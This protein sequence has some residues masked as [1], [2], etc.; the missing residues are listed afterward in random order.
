M[1]L[2]S[3]F[4]WRYAP[5]A[6]FFFSCACIMIVELVAGRLIAGHLGS[7]LY[8]WT[9]VIGVTLAGIT[10]GNLLGGRMAD[11]YR[12]EAL[13]RWL[14]LAAALACV[15]SLALNSFFATMRPLA[16]LDWPLRILLTVFAIFI[17][18]AACLGTLS[19]SL[20]KIAV[21]RARH[22]GSALGSF[23][24]CGTVGSIAGTF[25]SGFWLIFAVGNTR[26][27]V[28]I[29]AV[30]ALLG[31]LCSAFGGNA[32]TPD[33]QAGIGPQGVAVPGEPRSGGETPGRP[34]AVFALRYTPHAIAFLASACLMVVELLA[35][36]VIAEQAGSS[37]YTWASVIGVVFAGMSLG[38]YAGGLLSDRFP[39]SR[40]IGWLFLAASASVVSVLVAAYVLELKAPFEAWR[41]PT[42]VFATVFC[43][44]FLPSLVLGTFVPVAVKAAVER[45]TELGTTIGSVSAWNAVGS[46]VGTVAAG[47]WLIPAL[48]T[49]SLTMLVACVLA[50]A[51]LVLGP[52]RVAHLGWTAIAFALL[53]STRGPLPGVGQWRY[54]EV[55]RDTD[56]YPF[57]AESAYQY[58]RVYDDFSEDEPDRS[59]RVLSLDHLIHGYVD[60][61]DPTFLN[62]AYERVY[63]EVARR[64]AAGKTTVSAF[65]V[66]GGSYTFPRWVLAQWPGSL[67]VVGEIDPVVPEAN[68]EATG[69]PRT[70]PI[71]TIIGDARNTVE[72]LPPDPRFDFFFGDAFNDLAV[73]YHLTT[74]EFSRNVAQHLKPGGA[75]LVNLID[76]FDSGL[77][78]GSF[79]GALQREFSHVYVF[80]TEREGVSHRRDTF[81]V[82][83]SN[84]PLDTR[85]W[86]R[87]HGTDFEGSVLTPADLAALEK[88]C[89]GRILTDDNAPVEVLIAPVVRE[90]TGKDR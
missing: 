50:A 53:L 5:H 71:H 62:Y 61:N 88:K 46:I 19:P 47:F 24:G 15:L 64:Y 30:L 21:E 86:E 2:M 70:T 25:V 66:G 38:N 69:L 63:A 22:T 67:A 29:A 12:P 41:W 49:Q 37:L 57:S 52:R 40:V 31:A 16:G 4:L 39:S 89:G 60:L 33:H 84:V 55:F 17:L 32:A 9:A 73:P 48:G 10:A 27:T 26:T 28:A 78:L 77:L 59:L 74:L 14:F 20:A 7:S 85:G 82:A 43:I 13:L 54:Q 87:N 11:R 18:P 6:V 68:Y 34:D 36:R 45:A 80:C 23:Y 1:S 35:S 8:T 56:T 90:R 72:D 51:G 75:Y 79:V 44:F 3:R 58:V 42:M 65:F 83:A 76:N 81:V